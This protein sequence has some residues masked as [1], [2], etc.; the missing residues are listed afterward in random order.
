[1]YV[2]SSNTQST[3][4]C[5][6]LSRIF[7]FI[8]SYALAARLMQPIRDCLKCMCASWMQQRGFAKFVFKTSSLR[9]VRAEKRAEENKRAN[10]QKEP[11]PTS[12]VPTNILIFMCQFLVERI[13]FWIVGASSKK[14]K[15]VSLICVG[16][17]N[18]KRSGRR[19]WWWWLLSKGLA[20]TKCIICYQSPPPKTHCMKHKCK[21][22]RADQH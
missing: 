18:F 14:K 6:V 17:L 10:A 12:I 3:S 4:L 19:K 7:F 22:N 9:R 16:D 15:L 5:R 20:I 2:R 13:C 8:L 21:Y 1:M 11:E